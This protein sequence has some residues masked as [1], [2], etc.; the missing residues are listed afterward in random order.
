M[1]E[2]VGIIVI[3][4][5]ALTIFGSFGATTFHLLKIESK[6]TDQLFQYFVQSLAGIAVFNALVGTAS[7]FIP[8][9]ANITVLLAIVGIT[10]LCISSVR[11]NFLMGFRGF[12]TLTW[13]SKILL[14]FLVTAVFWVTSLD[15]LNYDSGLY[16]NQFIMW[17]NQ[18]PAVPGL[19][20][21]HE[22]FGFNSHW[23]LLAASFNGYPYTDFGFNDMGS[24]VVVLFLGAAVEGVHALVNEGS[25]KYLHGLMALSLVP[26]YLLVRFFTSDTPDLPNSLIGFAIL[27]IPF[28]KGW[29][30][31][32]RLFV[33][34]VVGGLLVSIKVSSVLLLAVAVP[35]L[36]AVNW[37]R[38]AYSLLL[39]LLTLSPWISRNYIFSGYL[40]YPAKFTAL[41]SPDY[42]APVE[43]LEYVN[44]LLESHGRFGRYDVNL[45]NRPVSEWGHIWLKHQTT[46]IKLILVF[47]VLG[48]LVFLLYDGYKILS[49][50]FGYVESV[51]LLVHIV[52]LLSMLLVFKLAPEIRYAYGVLL[53]YLVYQLL[54]LGISRFNW[55]I[56]GISMFGCL[57]F[58]RMVLIVNAEPPAMVLS[59]TYDSID[60]SALPIYYPV[61]F[62]QCW[63]H[64][65]PCANRYIEGL[66][67]RTDK[68]EDGFR[69]SK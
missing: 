14:T 42:Q 10:L 65:L 39:G 19:A 34:A 27:T 5:I 18:Y 30:N 9:T 25:R 33:I 60:G 52:F 62:D 48:F 17:M 26:L 68:L 7:L 46:S 20:N 13:Y 64:E 63:N 49:S 3:W 31:Q 47:C 43:S 58:V 12:S 21:L 29:G 11:D 66:E 50:S 69:I 4:A 28:Y 55:A 59:K 38:F 23:H 57:M 56:V 36:V 67:M 22:R 32:D 1:I 44:A 24:L 61:E 51:N 35:S 8:V 53:F 40:V 45:V 6:P 2:N 54:R 16:H 41:G 37:K 15:S